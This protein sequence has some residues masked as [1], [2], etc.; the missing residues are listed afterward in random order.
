MARTEYSL[1]LFLSIFNELNEHEHFND[2]KL[3]L[4][5]SLT[6]TV[7]AQSFKISCLSGNGFWLVY[8]DLSNDFGRRNKHPKSRYGMQ[9]RLRALLEPAITN[10]QCNE[11]NRGHP[12][13]F[14]QSQDGFR[15][16]ES[17]FVYFG[18][19]ANEGL[20][21]KS[22]FPTTKRQLHIYWKAPRK[23]LGGPGWVHYTVKHFQRQAF[24]P[25][26]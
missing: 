3:W 10:L 21:V 6:R 23:T 5:R 8:E 22:S 15:T 1:K 24:K 2:A 20:A 26:F 16:K 11:L 19:I 4:G 14:Y 25:H 17:E 7:S 9:T 13:F 18:P 12:T